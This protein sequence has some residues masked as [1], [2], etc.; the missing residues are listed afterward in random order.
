MENRIQAMLVCK[1]NTRKKKC[2]NSYPKPFAENAF[3]GDNAYSTYGRKNNGYKMMVHGYEVD[4]RWIVPYNASLL[5]KLNIRINVKIYSTVK[6]VKYIYIY[7]YKY[8]IRIMTRFIS[9]LV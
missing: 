8:I 4:N 6:V 3:H 1:E 7:I 2:I 5:A 9:E